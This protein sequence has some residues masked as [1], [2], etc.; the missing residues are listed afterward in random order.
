[1]LIEVVIEIRVEDDELDVVEGDFIL[2]ARANVLDLDALDIKLSLG[3]LRCGRSDLPSL[4]VDDQGMDIVKR[5][6]ACELLR[7][8][9]Y[10]M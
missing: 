10:C 9:A 6:G 7:S 8:S 2:Y 3:G 1:M 4:L 5:N